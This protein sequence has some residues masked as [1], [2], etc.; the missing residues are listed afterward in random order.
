MA[1]STVTAMKAA[2]DPEFHRWLM[3]GRA[4]AM[5]EAQ[6]G[7][8]LAY[9]ETQGRLP[10]PQLAV[11]KR[12]ERAIADRRGEK[13]PVLMARQSGKNETEAFV[14]DRMLTVFAHMQGSVWVRWI[15]QEA[16]HTAKRSPQFADTY[17]QLARR[18]GKQIAT[19]AIARRLLARSFH[20]LKEVQTAA[21]TTGEGQTGRARVSA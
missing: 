16:A 9:H 13:I 5:L 6:L 19:V 8:P 1:V 2:Q 11:V 14:E 3:F 17:S 20:I 4:D 21:T 18:R 10:W 15:L 7:R 12:I